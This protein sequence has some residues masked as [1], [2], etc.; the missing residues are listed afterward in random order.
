MRIGI[1]YDS[2]KEYLEMGYTKEQTAEFDSEETINEISESLKELGH[3]VVKIGHLKKLMKALTDG[4]RWDIVFNIAE[5][6]YGI[7]R[8]SQIPALL[9][10]YNIP[11]TFSDP[12]VLALSLHKGMAK[13]VIRDLNIPTAPF[14]II[15]NKEQL[16]KTRFYKFPAFIK[17]IAEGTGKGISELSKIEDFDDL[18]N[19]TTVILEKYKQPVIVEEFLPGRE[20][21]VGIVGTGENSKVIGVMEILLKE[22]AEKIG[23][24]YENKVNY[25]EVVEYKLIEEGA[26]EKECERIALDS[27][28]GLGCRDGGRIDLKLDK[29][30]VPNFIEVNPLA[31]LDPVHSDLPILC[32]KKG[33]TYKELIK[34]ILNSALERACKA[35]V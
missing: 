20:F 19:N 34:Y 12:M 25:Q 29:Y 16:A 9:D 35:K 14:T 18:I 33:I 26:L 6:M 22:N 2:K 7:G 28:K 30:G 5:G 24:S 1:T 11:Y 27:W 13:R 32:Y 10:A 21:T 31:G 23:Y 15:E 8:E 4:E 3:E 17:P